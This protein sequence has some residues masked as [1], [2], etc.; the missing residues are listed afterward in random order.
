MEPLNNK[1]THKQREAE[2]YTQEQMRLLLSMRD[3]V[4][5]EVR[6]EVARQLEDYKK[7]NNYSP[8]KKQ[9]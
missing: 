1:L 9:L 7:N 2:R 3:M 4:K 6:K 8:F 5:N